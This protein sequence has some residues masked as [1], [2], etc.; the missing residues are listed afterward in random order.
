MVIIHL[1]CCDLLIPVLINLV[2]IQFIHFMGVQLF[3]PI[4]SE[5]LR[6]GIDRNEE[7]SVASRVNAYAI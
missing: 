2:E 3:C 5:F 7:S 1:P 4:Y 6:L